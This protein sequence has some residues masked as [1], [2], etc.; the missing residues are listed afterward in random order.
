MLAQHDDAHQHRQATDSGDDESLQRSEPAG[1]ARRVVPDE[2][3]RENRREF[4]E[5]VEH[6][7][8]VGDH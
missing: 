2:Q 1:P 7:Q 3:V 4:P 6:D 5:D 8:V